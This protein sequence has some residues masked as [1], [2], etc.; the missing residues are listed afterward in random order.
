MNVSSAAGGL[1]LP[2]SGFSRSGG[3]GFCIGRYAESGS[4]GGEK[5]K[6]G[7]LR[8]GK[9]EDPGVYVAS[10]R[11][12]GT[13]DVNLA[14]ELLRQDVLYLD[15]KA[16]HDVS[17]IVAAHDKV[18]EVL[19]PLVREQRS[20]ET[21]R[22]ELNNLQVELSK[23]HSQVHL[24]E[25]RVAHTLQKLAEME[26]AVNDKLLEQKKP[27]RPISAPKAVSL[28]EGVSRRTDEGS[29][30]SD[31]SAGLSRQK[32]L[33][34]SGPVGSY[35]AKFK[36][37]W[38]PVAFS[39]DIDSKTMV[40]FES[41]E[42]SWVIFR[43]K[44]GRPGCVHDAC[45]H[46]ACPLSLG[47]VE[48]G[49]IQCPYHGWEY[50][51]TG[52]CEKMPSTR[53]VNATLQSLPCIEQDGMVWIW[54]G[55][56]TPTTAL[57]ALLPPANYTI[58]AQIVLELP[59]EHG[60]LVENLLDLAHA[61]FTHTTTFARGWKVP[62]FVKFRTPMAKL[63]GTWDPYPIAMEFQPPCMVLST[64]GLEKPGKLDGSDVD[65]CPTHLHQLHVCMPSSPGKTRLL[66]RMALDFAPF[67]KHVPFIH[68]L[69]Q[70]LANKVLGED[71]RLVEGQQNR[72]QR[73]ANVW[74]L[75]VSYDK[76]GV[77]YRQWRKG[78]EAGEEQIP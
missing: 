63:Q 17:T 65:L 37:F 59:V 14:W 52:R 76:L 45:A 5:R 6:N 57:P 75:P 72:M 60:L 46:R 54:P 9:L 18:V 56:A 42:E 12:G 11:E 25:A 39:D 49:R 16:R 53:Q 70:H 55:S 67:L 40:P 71:L 78:I 22:A 13:Y 64:I 66:Y 32:F 15:W 27:H 68:F 50:G 34:V 30:V 3:E 4:S 74:N 38:Y 24:S 73:G 58:H 48:D 23:A 2:V 20:V 8:E 62:S 51:N 43:G 7:I 33:D 10:K 28:D 36:D 41:F 26:M 1:H 21:M 44:D 77:R 29:H 69:W 31:S 47:K 35:P 61:P 19:N